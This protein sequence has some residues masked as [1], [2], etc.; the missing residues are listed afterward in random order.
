MCSINHEKKAIFIHIPKTAG[1]YIRQTLTNH[2]GFDLYLSKRPDHITFCKTNLALNKNQQLYF[3][4]S[5]EG[6]INYY[7]TSKELSDL[8]NM[9]DHKWDTYFK[10][11]FVRNPYE[12]I[13]SGWNYICQV[14]HLNI[15]FKKY[16]SLKNIVN[17]EE[18]FHVFL[19][20]SKQL[21]NEKNEK[22]IDF[23]GR[24]E[25][26]E[27]DFKEILLKIGFDEN[28]INHDPSEK[29]NERPH[30]SANIIISDQELLDKVNEIC[31][32]DF[33][34]LSDMYS[35]ITDINQLI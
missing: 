21:F 15:G 9:D 31:Q 29:K 28:E 23:I 7:K 30:K 1:I 3:A 22:Y 10:F 12:R 5:A 32:P 18:Y 11:C 19:P 17:E 14:H 8:M 2:Y 24:F 6:V 16:L 20:Q 33:D 4:N 27:D 26:L 13:I 34:V 35:K 25:Y